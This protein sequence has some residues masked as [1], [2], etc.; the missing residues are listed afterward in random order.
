VGV[1]VL[2]KEVAVAAAVG[3]GGDEFATLAT[4]REDET[5]VA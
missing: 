2:A 4:A 5:G 3:G 1:K